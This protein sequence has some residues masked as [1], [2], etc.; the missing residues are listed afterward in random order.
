MVTFTINC[1][2]KEISSRDYV[3]ITNVELE[4]KESLLKNSSD[5]A[6]P[7]GSTVLH[8]SLLALPGE[9]NL[10]YI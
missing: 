10:S 4:I 1:S 5:T 3:M 8:L 9:M 2:S 7:S 6:C